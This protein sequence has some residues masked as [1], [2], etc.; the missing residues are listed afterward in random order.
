MDKYR[1]SQ[2]E[3]K[4]IWIVNHKLR[5]NDLLFHIRDDQNNIIHPDDM[6]FV[7]EN[8]IALYFKEAKT[9]TIMVEKTDSFLD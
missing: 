3:P 2:T 5:T 4:K 8:I 1:H 7:T 9:G 6:E